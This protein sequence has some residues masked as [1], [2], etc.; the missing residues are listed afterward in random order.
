MSAGGKR[1]FSYL[2]TT[3]MKTFVIIWFGQLVSLVGT[4]MTRFALLIWAYDLTGSA[5]TVAL[6]GFFA[7]VPYVLVSP[8]AGAWV[9]RLDRRLVMLFS[10][11][12]A[13]IMTIGVYFLFVNG[14]LEIWHLF[15]AQALAG[16][17]EAFQT[18]AYIASTTLLVDKSQ[19]GRI[20]GMRSIAESASQIIGPI[21][22]GAAL[23]FINIDGVMLIDI[24]TFLIAMVTLLII[25]IPNPPEETASLTEKNLWKDIRL[26]FD[27]IMARKGLR[28]LL[29]IYVGINLFAAL[30]YFAVMPSLIL[31]RTGGNE[32]ALA[33]VEGML[34]LGGVVGGVVLSVWGGPK[35]QIHGVLAGA[36]IS[37]F[38]GDLLFAV[39]QSVVVWGAGAF[40]A[41]FF[42]PFIMGGNRAIWQSKVPPA[43]QGRVFSV[44]TMLQTGMMPIGY[45]AAGPLADLVFEPAMATNGRL[46][47]TFGWLVGTGAGAGMGLMF[48][49]TA[50]LGLLMSLSG[51]LFAA[52]RN[53]ETELPDYDAVIA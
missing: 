30:T 49:G 7:F 33:I 5:T 39:G 13:G 28:G 40:L 46:A 8:V 26:G 29:F 21:A 2:N 10:D 47:E 44:Q 35:R 18:P 14:Q 20:S 6:L 43:I 50:V 34:G 11:L 51:Y 42:I 9:D 27:Y 37:F 4:A 24:G 31:A 12:G 53:V 52:V 25:R 16:M 23:A 38:L 17:F 15:I 45:L 19:Y 1:P 36:A 32:Q 3:H 48:L 41:A 22:A